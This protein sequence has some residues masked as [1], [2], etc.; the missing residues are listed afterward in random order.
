[1]DSTQD[2]IASTPL[3][4]AYHIDIEDLKKKLKVHPDDFPTRKDALA[5]AVERLDDILTRIDELEGD[6]VLLGE[7]PTAEEVKQIANKWQNIALEVSS[8]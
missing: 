8:K 5:F 4:S 3:K 6:M 7:K 1:M 2:T